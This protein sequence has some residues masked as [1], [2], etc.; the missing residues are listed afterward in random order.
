VI[1]IA[2]ST[3]VAFAFEYPR[4]AQIVPDRPMMK[5]N[6][7][8]AM[9]LIAIAVRRLAA[10][11]HGPGGA[12]GRI[13]AAIALVIGAISL[14]ER[15]L[16]F[17]VGIDELLLDDPWTD[18]R[19]RAP[20]RPSLGAA[21]GITLLA[22]AIL[23]ANALLAHTLV[24]AMTLAAASIGGL[25]M[26]GMVFDS[27]ALYGVRPF[28]SVGPSSAL[29]LVLLSIGTLA[30]MPDR[31]VASLVAAD[32]VGGALT[33][34]M[35]PIAIATPFA[36][37]GVAQ[38]AA[39]RG[40]I[41]G[42]MATAMLVVALAAVMGG[43]VLRAASTIHRL[44]GMR[45]RSDGM[46]R[47]SSSRV[48]HLSAVLDASNVPVVSFDGLGRVVTWNPAAERAFGRR[49]STAIGR[50]SSEVFAL[51]TARAISNALEPALRRGEA[52]QVEIAVERADGTRVA[53]LLSV[54]PL[55]DWERRVSG[56]C[57]VLREHDPARAQERT[58]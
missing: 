39:G 36:L 10:G 49:A 25:A 26:L 58:A 52:R 14:T 48:R 50:R 8:V 2:L 21:G 33:R 34:R 13:A 56:A 22:T 28:T 16:E 37:V 53:G 5:P 27:G 6:T 24:Q 15:Y 9:I 47:E 1:V 40:W 18:P 3:L 41:E 46:L 32:S 51:E 35:A 29:S 7:A 12:V 54:A 4:L 19:M 45:A 42:G 20:G 38:I 55:L 57:A 11:T 23:L 17:D 43:L 30:A 31:G 44:E